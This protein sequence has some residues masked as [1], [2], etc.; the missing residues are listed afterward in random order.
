MGGF[1]TGT[2]MAGGRRSTGNSRSALLF[3]LVLAC[4]LALVSSGARTC[5]DDQSEDYVYPES[6]DLTADVTSLPHPPPNSH[7]L[8]V[9]LPLF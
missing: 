4:R 1:C 7:A 6:G 8:P 3:V 9:L 5:K 2:G